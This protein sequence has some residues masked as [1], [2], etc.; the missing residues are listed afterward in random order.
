[1][2]NLLFSRMRPFLAAFA[3]GCAVAL[4]GCGKKETSATDLE[5]VFSEKTK[6][7]GGTDPAV[8]QAVDQA[9]AAIKANDNV[10]AVVILDTLR[11]QPA[12]TPE[13]S[14]TVQD[15]MG[16]VQSK[17]AERADKGDPAAIQA[18]QAIRAGKR[19]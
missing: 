14:M 7:A 6:G 3:V 10:G 19:R 2:N 13:Q 9:A 16:T 4:S 5:K 18:L 12:L 1:M 15:M 17:L 8:K 11:R